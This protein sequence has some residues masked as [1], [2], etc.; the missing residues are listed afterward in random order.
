LQNLFVV[1]VKICKTEK[2]FLSHMYTKMRGNFTFS[3]I[4]KFSTTNNK[5]VFFC[6]LDKVSR[7]NFWLFYN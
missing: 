4:A 3:T 1:V 7:D 6:P 5:I 2:V